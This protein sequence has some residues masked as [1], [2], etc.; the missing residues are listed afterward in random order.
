MG[1]PVAPTP[2]ALVAAEF[3]SYL[4]TQKGLKVAGYLDPPRAPPGAGW[5]TYTYRLQLL[6][7]GRLPAA[8]RRP[9]GLR[10]YAGPEGLPRLRR[11]WT[12]Q[13]RLVELR[14]PVAR[15]VFREEDPSFLGGPFILMEW[16][17]GEPMLDRLRYDYFAFLWAPWATADL[18]ARLHRMPVEGLPVPERSFLDRQLETLEAA[19]QEHGLT[20]LAPGMDWLRAHRPPE[21]ETPSLLHL[22]FHPKNLLTRQGRIAAVLDWSESDFG[23]R[24]ADLGAALTLMD[25]GPLEDASWLDRVML[26]IGRFFMRAQY[27]RGYASRLPLDRKRLH[28]YQAWGALRRLSWYGCWVCAGP[29]VMGYKP[30]AVQHVRRRHVAALERYFEKYTGVAVQFGLALPSEAAIPAAA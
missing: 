1:T 10:V 7:S 26:P 5:E 4:Q 30:G 15:P 22:D 17:E 2:A 18:H 20:G 23:D 3:V 25:A 28:Y 11:D 27:C 16:V 8:L 21:P 29:H 9:L 12:L 13:T 14:Y 19:V 24:H 6:P